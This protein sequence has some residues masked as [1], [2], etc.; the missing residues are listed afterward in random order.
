MTNWSGRCRCCN[1][2]SSTTS[3]PRWAIFPNLP[4]A[5]TGRVSVA[6]GEDSDQDQLPGEPSARESAEKPWTSRSLKGWEI[7]KRTA[8][9]N[10]SDEK[11][12]LSVQV[13][14]DLRGNLQSGKHKRDLRFAL[15]R[16]WRTQSDTNRSTSLNSVIS[17]ENTGNFSNSRRAD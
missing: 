5:E 16:R 4:T 6:I 12:G 1:W 2:P 8:S 14:H 9:S 17:S 13:A 10:L 15:P 7:R 3:S 11:N